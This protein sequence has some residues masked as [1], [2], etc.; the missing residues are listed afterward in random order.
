M[1]FKGRL[2]L[3]CCASAG[4]AIAFWRGWA[5][6]LVFLSAVPALVCAKVPNTAR[7]LLCWAAG[8]R[9]LTDA[10]DCSSPPT[11]PS[12]PPASPSFQVILT[13][14]VGVMQTRLQAKSNK[15]Y[16]SAASLSQQ[17]LSNIR[18]VASYTLEDPT[19]QSYQ[20]ALAQPLKVGK[21]CLGSPWC[22]CCAGRRPALGLPFDACRWASG[23]A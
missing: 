2:S 16:A 1:V 3:R 18:T 6:T 7:K 13:A 19:V 15:A 5:L 10:P 20:A 21:G 14:A 4:T 11:C 9:C 12:A 8:P 17:A 23:R 22:A